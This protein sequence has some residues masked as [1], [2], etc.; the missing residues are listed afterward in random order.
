MT[1]LSYGWL[2]KNTARRQA[3]KVD[4][5]PDQFYRF[6]SYRSSIWKGLSCNS[7]STFLLHSSRV[8]LLQYKIISI[9]YFQVG[10][11]KVGLQRILLREFVSTSAKTVQS[12]ILR[13]TIKLSFCTTGRQ[14]SGMTAFDALK[15]FSFFFSAGRGMCLRS[16][17]GEGVQGPLP[18]DK[19]LHI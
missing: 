4:F 8:A 19:K 1:I 17:S 10:L 14:G 13:L 7:I 18:F 16:L 12:F 11:L 6:A 3:I 9:Y 15:F 2:P 5:F